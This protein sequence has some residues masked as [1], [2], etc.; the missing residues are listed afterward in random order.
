MRRPQPWMGIRYGR[1]RLWG[2][3]LC[4]VALSVALLGAA[5]PAAAPGAERSADEVRARIEAASH[6][7][8]DLADLDLTG[9]DLAGVDFQGADLRGSVLKGANLGK[10]L[11]KVA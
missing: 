5:W 7:P 6:A 11:V 4:N 10:Q 9:L 8:P 2:P 1:R 3:R